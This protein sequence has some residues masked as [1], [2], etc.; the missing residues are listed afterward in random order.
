M[1]GGGRWA[2]EAV[3]RHHHHQ[4]SN[5]HHHLN[6]MGVWREEFCWES[7]CQHLNHHQ[8]Q[9]NLILLATIIMV[10]T[11]SKPGVQ[12]DHQ[13]LPPLPH[14]AVLRRSPGEVAI[15]I[16]VTIIVVVVILPSFFCL[17]CNYDG[18]SNLFLLPPFVHVCTLWLT[19]NQ[20]TE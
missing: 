10:M 18:F 19:D 7:H 15:I 9:E 6:H 4:C 13:P 17:M 1:A 11:F 12:P 14:S 5:R 8:R 2:V 16:I 3:L 20:R